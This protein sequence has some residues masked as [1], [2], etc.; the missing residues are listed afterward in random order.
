MDN[1]ILLVD[2]EEE[3]LGALELYLNRHGYEVIKA[4]SGTAAIE[5]VKRFTPSLIISKTNFPDMSGAELLKKARALVPE[6][7]VIL[8]SEE[9]DTSSK[10][11]CLALPVL[12]PVF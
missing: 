7:E 12:L 10:A 8:I 4:D 6:I 2:D 11:E 5:A 1:S 3:L 9:R